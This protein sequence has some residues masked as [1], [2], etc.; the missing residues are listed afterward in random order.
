MELGSNF[1][2]DISSLHNVEDNIFEYLKPYFTFY[3]DS[4]RSAIRVLKKVIKPGVVLLPCYICDSIIQSFGETFS[5]VFYKIDEDFSVDREDFERKLKDEVSVVY[6]MHYFGQLQD[7][8]F[9]EYIKE[10][11]SQY[12]FTVIEDTT[13][14]IFTKSKTIGDYCICSLRKWFP[15]MDGG[16]LYSDEELPGI[17]MEGVLP[18]NPSIKLEAMILKKL[19]IEGKLDNNGLYRRIFEEEEDKLIFQQTVFQ[20][21]L[22]SK[23]LLKYFSVGELIRRRKENYRELQKE[24]SKL[25]VELVLRGN[26]FVPLSCPI[27]IGNRDD[28]RNYLIK[29]NVFCAI[30]WPLEGTVLEGDEK[31]M[32]MSGHI[33]SLPIDQRYGR[34][35]MQYLINVVKTYFKT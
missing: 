1:E 18:K 27:Y 7:K 6:I 10:S 29:N 34:E 30:H 22:L 12:G 21:S 5:V 35:Q 33:I 20:I 8:G 24:I 13:H 32:Q 23:C 31:A 15:I 16:V 3:T 28:F 25:G 17:L 2:L 9:L 14:S 11:K 26:E 4:G 19:Y